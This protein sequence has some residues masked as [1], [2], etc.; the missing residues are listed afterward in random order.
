MT[1]GTSWR[2]ATEADVNDN[3][4]FAVGDRILALTTEGKEI[5]RTARGLLAG[6][7]P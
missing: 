3:V 2:E 4:D 6:A 7:G 5:V 1:E